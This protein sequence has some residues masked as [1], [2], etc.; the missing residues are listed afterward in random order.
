MKS[1]QFT[2]QDKLQLSLQDQSSTTEVMPHLIT[3]LRTQSNEVQQSM[4]QTVQKCH[5]NSK[6]E[7]RLSVDVLEPFHYQ[8]KNS[9]KSCLTIDNKC[10]DD[11]LLKLNELSQ[12]YSQLVLREDR[13]D[14]FG[15]YLASL[16][17]SLPSQT[18]MVLQK[19]VKE[20]ILELHIEPR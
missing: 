11:V 19:K 17:R 15:N 9:S 1:N 16:L 8:C 20:L 2:D 12:K 6:G 5:S 18:A 3:S 13:F 4:T 14:H 7:N 10:I